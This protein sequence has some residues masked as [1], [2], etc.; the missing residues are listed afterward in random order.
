MKT[1]FRVLIF[2]N[3]LTALAI[4]AKEVIELVRYLI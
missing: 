3:Y 2:F 1:L 4:L